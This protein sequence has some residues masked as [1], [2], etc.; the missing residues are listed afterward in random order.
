MDDLEELFF[1]YVLK[2]L[3]NLFF[4]DRT[5]CFSV[6]KLEIMILSPGLLVNLWLIE[7]E[8]EV[9]KFRSNQKTSLIS[10]GC[11]DK[12]HS[13]FN[14]LF[15]SRFLSYDDNRDFE[16]LYLHNWFQIFQVFLHWWPVCFSTFSNFHSKYTNFHC[17][18]K[19]L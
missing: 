14:G 18:S 11:L 3:T 19:F 9:W 10:R 8:L 17:F 2:I 12:Q 6:S 7:T 4:F 1:P 13:S 5:I 15:S 16:E